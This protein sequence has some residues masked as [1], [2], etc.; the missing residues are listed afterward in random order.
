[1]SLTGLVRSQFVKLFLMVSV[2]AALSSCAGYTPQNQPRLTSI[3]VSPINA[4]LA[5][6]TSQQVGS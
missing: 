4:T 3:D 5:I 1:M 6:G 2:V